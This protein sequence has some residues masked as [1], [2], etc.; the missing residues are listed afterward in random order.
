MESIKKF[1]SWAEVRLD[2]LK[3]NLQIARSMIAGDSE[4]MAVVK[5]DAYGHGAVQTAQALIDG[6]ADKLAVATVA[7]GIELREHDIRAPILVLGIPGPGEAEAI[8]ACRLTASIGNLGYAQL[9]NRIAGSRGEKVKVH[10]RV[11]T[12]M[13]SAGVLTGE[14]RSLLEKLEELKHLEIEGIYTHLNAA[15]GEDKSYVQ[16]QLLEFQSVLDELEGRGMR[17]PLIHAASSPALGIPGSEYRMIRPGIML[18]GLQSR[19]QAVDEQIKP[20]MQLKA[21]V[22]CIK[23]VACDFKMGYGWSL[24]TACPTRI[25]TL[26][27]GYADAFF[28]HFISSPQV[29]IHGQRVPL[30]GRTCMDHCMADITGLNGVEIGDEAVF[31]GEQGDARITVEELTR[32]AGIGPD[33]CDLICLLGHRV[34]RIYI[35]AEE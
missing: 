16:V 10:V 2:R 15:Y 13:G 31:F 1:Q 5:A 29:L 7:E 22:T 24:S 26:P 19:N 17:I 20:V 23:E 6:G 30:L 25:A 28:L 34:P 27:L 11:D 35:S 4:I 32:K 8:A 3:H 12:G 18:Y 14:C 9:L 33:N 21:R